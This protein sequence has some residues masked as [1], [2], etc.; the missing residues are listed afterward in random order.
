MTL[1]SSLR[2]KEM[3]EAR[4]GS[5]EGPEAEEAGSVE[6][7]RSDSDLPAS[8]CGRVGGTLTG[9]ETSVTCTCTCTCICT[10]MCITQYTSAT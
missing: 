2:D 5:L 8:L 10:C 9:F 1:L 4:G 6:E 3:C 7:T